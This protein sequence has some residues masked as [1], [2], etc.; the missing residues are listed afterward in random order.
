[1][2]VSTSSKLEAGLTG[3]SFLFLS[4]NHSLQEAFGIDSTHIKA[5]MEDS[6]KTDPF[7]EVL[8]HGMPWKRHTFQ[9][10][11]CWNCCFAVCSV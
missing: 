11:S 9:F 10:E 2:G 4:A 3:E 6:L 5:T 7:M 1:M 8:T